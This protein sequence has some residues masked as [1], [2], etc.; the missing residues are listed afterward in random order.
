M[1]FQ[2]SIPVTDGPRA[3]RGPRSPT[4]AVVWARRARM[5]RRGQALVRP[6]THRTSCSPGPA[7]DL[8][9]CDVGLPALD[10]ELEEHDSADLGPAGRTAHRGYWLGW[11]GFLFRGSHGQS[12]VSPPTPRGLWPSIMVSAETWAQPPRSCTMVRPAPAPPAHS[13]TSALRRS[14]VTGGLGA[15]HRPGLPAP[16]PVPALILIAV[17]LPAQLAVPVPVGASRLLGHDAPPAAA[18]PQVGAR[19]AGPLRRI[20]QL[21]R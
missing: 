10:R 19:G 18:G 21:L 6:H 13:T 17:H 8:H 3:C 14:E 11:P 20:L 4:G 5:S 2:A 7:L 16:L 1:L 15:C 9:L 12:V